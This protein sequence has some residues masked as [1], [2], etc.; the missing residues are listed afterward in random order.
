MNCF[1]RYRDWKESKGLSEIEIEFS[2]LEELFHE[3]AE[4]SDRTKIHSVI[5]VGKSSQNE[6]LELALE[7]TSL[8]KK[9]I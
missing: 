6:K 8:V 2:S 5:L 3:L 7:I 4:S 1:I 9:K